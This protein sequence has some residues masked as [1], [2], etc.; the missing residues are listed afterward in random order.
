ML[1]RLV[2]HIKLNYIRKNIA[3]KHQLGGKIC[4]L[5]LSFMFKSSIQ[6]TKIR[7]HIRKFKIFQSVQSIRHCLVFD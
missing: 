7:V 3:N 5:G 2:Q 1:D 6:R 4:R